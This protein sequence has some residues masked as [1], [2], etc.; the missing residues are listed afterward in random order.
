MRTV[1]T[2]V[3]EDISGLYDLWTLA[4]GDTKE[5]IDNFF[6]RY[7]RPER[8]LVLEEGQIRRSFAGGEIN[9][10]NIREALNCENNI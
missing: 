8:V 4:F 6:Q 10:A 2:S 1:R 9:A 5:Y 7:Y 3:R